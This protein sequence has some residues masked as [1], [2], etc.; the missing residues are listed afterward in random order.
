MRIDGE[1]AAQ[2]V[3][4]CLASMF[5][6]SPWGW[7]RTR[8][9]LMAGTSGAPIAIVNGVWAVGP[10]CDAAEVAELLDGVAATGLPYCLQ[11]RD[12]QLDGLAV[13]RGMIAE[14]EIPLMVIDDLARLSPPS[15]V[16]AAVR[17]LDSNESD[18]HARAAADAYGAP[19]ELFQ[20]LVPPEVFGLPGLRGYVIEAD[21]GPVATGVG[22]VTNDHV[23]VY[24]IVTAEPY[25]RRG[26]AAAITAQAVRDGFSAGASFGWLQSTPAGYL[27]YRDLGFETLEHWKCWVA[28]PS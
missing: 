25:R 20:Q 8:P 28:P 5:L 13:A 21:G 27:V 10:R 17:R 12:A 15:A 23:G 26:F 16:A 14:P 9:G 24:N 2:A 7:V 22:V 19:I 3:A 11:A 1:R 6:A 4:D 18:V